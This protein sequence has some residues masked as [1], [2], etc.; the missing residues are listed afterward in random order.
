MVASTTALERAN[1]DVWEVGSIVAELWE[2]G[3]VARWSESA[4]RVHAL[5]R[6]GRAHADHGMLWACL[7]AY[8]AAGA[9]VSLGNG[10]YRR[11]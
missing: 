6:P 10:R 2:R 1:E 11:A 3:E 8:G 7:G 4:G 5:S 9:C